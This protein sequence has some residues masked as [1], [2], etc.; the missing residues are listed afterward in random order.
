MTVHKPCRP[1][2]R[3]F[4]PALAASLLI[5]ATT[6]GA[7]GGLVIFGVKEEGGGLDSFAR[8]I[9]L[10]TGTERIV[11]TQGT[12]VTERGFDGQNWLSVNG[13]QVIVDL[14][15]E[16][17]DRNAERW[18][19]QSI[20]RL[21]PPAGKTSMTVQR[22]GASAVT[23]EF[24][25]R[26]RPAKAS[27]DSDYGPIQFTFS[28]WKTV[29]K[30]SYPALIERSTDTGEQT[31]LYAGSLRYLRTVDP[32]L[33]ARP[34]P[35]RRAAL[36]K[37][38]VVPFRT[39]GRGTHMLVDAV[40]DGRRGQFV[41]DTGAANIFTVPAAKDRGIVSKGGLNITGV[42]EGSSGGGFTMVRQVSLGEAVLTD[43]NFI[44]IPP[45]FPEV[46]GKPSPTQGLLGFEY[47]A[48]F[49]TSI[50]YKT[51][52]LTFR[53]SV[54][55]D[56]GGHRLPIASDGHTL[57]A[58]AKING[59]PGW[60]RLDTGDGGGVTLF[61]AFAARAGLKPDTDPRM[62]GGGVGGGVREASGKV[63]RFE[64]GGAAFDDLAIRFALNTKGAF[65]SRFLAGNLG[66]RILSCFRM[67]LDHDRHQMWL[68]PQMDTP[69]CQSSASPAN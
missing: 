6:A 7:R 31:R 11:E 52:T 49:V 10:E 42:G 45:I 19:T 39:S 2:L 55:T 43:Q 21:T 61:P 28:D 64:F 23:I 15:S 20:G 60:F 22:A 26:R 17:A 44:I 34:A 16:V 58:Q 56:Q 18:L 54:P 46:D 36:S 63:A 33:L 69:T 66:G 29:G 27:I 68:E 32:Q 65:A 40:V 48:H 38:V 37:P 25:A 12:A 4:R 47:F 50:D 67:T 53:N 24:D 41:F 8:T 35:P 3:L 57:Y 5:F 59:Q 13:A 30:L 51:K 14:P 62:S 9:A 1:V